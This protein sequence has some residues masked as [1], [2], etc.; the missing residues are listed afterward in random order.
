MNSDDLDENDYS[1]SPSYWK[2]D[3]Q[4]TKRALMGL[5]DSRFQKK[6]CLP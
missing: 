5:G 6:K 3:F 4:K 1:S 2:G